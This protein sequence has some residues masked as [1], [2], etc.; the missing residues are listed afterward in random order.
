MHD[1]LYP[2]NYVDGNRTQGNTGCKLG[3]QNITLFHEFCPLGHVYD[4]YAPTKQNLLCDGSS[5]FDII[6]GHPNFQVNSNNND[7]I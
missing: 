1:S 6:L 3:T 4:R 7:K 5:A 2:L